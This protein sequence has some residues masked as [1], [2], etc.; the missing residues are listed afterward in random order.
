M[1]IIK[2][3]KM[4]GSKYKVFLDNG[5]NI[6]LHEN[7]II[8]YNLLITKKIEEDYDDIIK[9]NNNYMIYDMTVKYISKKMRCESEIR[10]YLKSKEINDELSDKI[11][12]KLRENG[13]LND[14]DY[15]KSYISD[16]VRLNNIGLNKIKSELYKLKLD[17]D[18]VDEEINALSQKILDYVKNDIGFYWEIGEEDSDSCPKIIIESFIKDISGHIVLNASCQLQS[19]EENAKC[20]Y[21]CKFP[22]KTEVGL[23]YNFA[24]QLPKFNEQEVGIRVELL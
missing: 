14:R 8:K 11:I 5:E 3:K 9:D 24:R 22:I 12:I 21:N 16:K 17:K 23:L 15:V 19:I 20:N 2:F 7:I 1:K 10:K 6:L 13:L 18:I 4:A